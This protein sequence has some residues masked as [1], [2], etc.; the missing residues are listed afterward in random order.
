MTSPSSVQGATPVGGKWLRDYCLTLTREDFERQHPHP[1]LVLGL[2]EGEED[3]T[4]HTVAGSE[5][6]ILGGGQRPLLSLR[7]GSISFLPLRERPGHPLE[8]G[9]TVGRSRDN[10][11]V[12]QHASVSKLHARFTLKAGQWWLADAG[13]LNGTFMSFRPVPSGQGLPIPDRAPLKFGSLRCTVLLRSGDLHDVL[14]G[15]TAR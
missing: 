7:S 14:A 3:L 9:L 5:L 15:G 6:G 12:L 11:V 8:D 4:L 10:D 2:E 1:W 13:S